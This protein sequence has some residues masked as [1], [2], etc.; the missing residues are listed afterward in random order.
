MRTIVAAAGTAALA[1]LL[2]SG[3]GQ[4]AHTRYGYLTPAPPATPSS[5]VRVRQRP[6][7]RAHRQQK[8]VKGTPCPRRSPRARPS[9]F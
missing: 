1:A 7:C 6:P 2:L 5:A 4:K 8:P 3:C 9:A